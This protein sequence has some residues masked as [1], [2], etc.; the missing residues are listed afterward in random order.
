LG[1]LSR[2][3]TPR[4]RATAAALSLLGVLAS[5]G[6]KEPTPPPA[7]WGTYSNRWYGYEFSFPPDASIVETIGGSSTVVYLH[8][9]TDPFASSDR[10]VLIAASRDGEECP[11]AQL[12]SESQAPIRRIRIGEIEFDVRQGVSGGPGRPTLWEA[13]ATERGG[14][15]VT[16]TYSERAGQATVDQRSQETATAEDSHIQFGGILA[17]F[18]WAEAE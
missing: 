18:R 10:F 5:C 12:V 14:K 2:L 16:I 4:F 3:S 13:Y 6:V 8:T 7:D 1:A 9:G 11:P 15:C 17:S